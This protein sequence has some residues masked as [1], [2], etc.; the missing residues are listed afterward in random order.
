MAHTKSADSNARIIEQ[1]TQGRKLRYIYAIPLIAAQTRNDMSSPDNMLADAIKS[2]TA[3]KGVFA[4]P[5]AGKVVRVYANALTYATCAASG[6][7]TVKATKGGAVDLNTAFNVSGEAG[8][9]P[10]SDTAIDGVLSTTAGALDLVEGQLVYATLVVS[11]HNITTCTDGLNL[12]VEF[13]PT[14]Q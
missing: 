7:V 10:V 11:A 2:T 5:C 13:A 4:A 6:T 1:C 9:V 14:E 12:N 8:S 3:C